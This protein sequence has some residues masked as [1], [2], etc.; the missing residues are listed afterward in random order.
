M[1]GEALGMND[2]HQARV[3]WRLVLDALPEEW[4]FLLWFATRAPG[5]RLPALREAFRDGVDPWKAEPPT[6]PQPE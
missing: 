4:C 2:E 6:G 5:A 1:G 3:L